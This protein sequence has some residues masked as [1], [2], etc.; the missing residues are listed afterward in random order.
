LLEADGEAGQSA[1][2]R[3]CLGDLL[4]CVAVFMVGLEEVV[5]EVFQTVDEVGEFVGDDRVVRPLTGEAGEDVTAVAVIV[6]CA[7]ASRR[8]LGSQPSDTLFSAMRSSSASQCAISCWSEVVMTPP[9]CEGSPRPAG[10]R[11]RCRA[12]CGRSG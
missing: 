7:S 8:S 12:G 3:Q 9:C 10:V 11:F 1:H 5:A 4:V 2:R 6:C